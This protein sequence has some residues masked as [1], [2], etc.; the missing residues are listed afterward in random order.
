MR[1]DT[2]QVIGEAA[3][4]EGI[5]GMHF[6][7]GIGTLPS[8]ARPGTPSTHPRSMTTVNHWTPDDIPDQTGRTR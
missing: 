2:I 5:L 7:T 4:A 3:S 8:A 1:L 6:R